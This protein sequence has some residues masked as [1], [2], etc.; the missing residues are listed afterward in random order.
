MDSASAELLITRKRAELEDLKAKTSQ[1]F[2]FLPTN[3]KFAATQV[4]PSC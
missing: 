4:S 1:Q 2:C 3:L